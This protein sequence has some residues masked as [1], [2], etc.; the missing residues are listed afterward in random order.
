MSNFYVEIVDRPIY[1]LD[2]DSSIN[3]EINNIEII[4][5][6]DYSLEIVNT[7]RVLASDLP[8][9]IPISKIVGNLPISRIDFTDE[10]GVG[11]DGLDAY[12]DQYEFECGPP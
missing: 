7:E 9:D 11:F 2:I 8:D 6:N 12:L 1:Y 10:Y 5:Y 3:N 4:K